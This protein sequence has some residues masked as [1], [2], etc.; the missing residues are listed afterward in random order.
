MLLVVSYSYSYSDTVNGVTNNAAANGLQWDMSDVLPPQ[1][2]LTV[3][4]L[5]YAYGVTKETEDDFTVTIENDD[6]LYGGYVFQETD[7][8]SGLPG[9]IIQKAIPL[10]DVLIDRMGDGRIRTEGNGTVNDPIVRYFY[11]YD[12]CFDPLASPECPGYATAYFQFLEDN[13]LL[14]EEKYKDPLED[15]NVL[16]ALNRDVDVEEEQE[17]NK[18]EDEE[19]EE[20]EEDLERMLALNDEV[21]DLAN[22]TAQDTMMLA[23]T[24]VQTLNTYIAKEL[25]GGTYTETVQLQDNRIDDNR[26]AALRMG[27]ASEM[28]HQDMVDLQY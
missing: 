13:G 17:E 25:E 21:N 24:Q 28:L 27:L 7:D 14:D 11:R 26:G 9:N 23:L 8:W 18:E 16:D 22:S 5:A 15:E 2:G 4:G 3:S 6:A 19:E 12:E 10:N 20:V 1:A